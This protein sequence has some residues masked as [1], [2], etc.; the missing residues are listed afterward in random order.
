MSVL[1]VILPVGLAS[2]FDESG[3]ASPSPH[4]RR[5]YARLKIRKCVDIDFL[6]VGGK[7]PRHSG[8]ALTSDL[9]KEGVGILYHEQVFPEERFKIRIGE[10]II[11]ALVMRCRKLGP[12]C[13]EVGAIIQETEMVDLGD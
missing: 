4:E 3:F 5:R 2:F 9:S 11:T 12:N 10:Q 7:P 6:G 8:K 1:Q 13:Y